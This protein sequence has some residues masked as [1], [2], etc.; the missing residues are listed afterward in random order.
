VCFTSMLQPMQDIPTNVLLDTVRKFSTADTGSATKP[1]V[2]PLTI[3]NDGITA[4]RNHNFQQAYTMFK[5]CVCRGSLSY[6][7]PA[8]PLS[9][10]VSR[11]VRAHPAAVQQV[12]PSY[13]QRVTELRDTEA[14]LAAQAFAHCA[15]LDA[16]E[17]RNHMSII[18]LKKALKLAPEVAEYQL[19]LAVTQAAVGEVCANSSL[20]LVTALFCIYICRT[21]VYFA[22]HPF[23]CC[24]KILFRL[25]CGGGL[26]NCL[27]RVFFLSG[28][29]LPY[30]CHSPM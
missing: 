29:L 14:S 24:A 20:K 2:D 11:C 4:A 21:H 28:A 7:H 16:Q 8:T 1:S 17:G 18:Q 3:F 22:A 25:V 26:I 30:P 15:I 10:L 12:T 6:G 5:V 19:Q 13:L 23:L 27:L 9:P